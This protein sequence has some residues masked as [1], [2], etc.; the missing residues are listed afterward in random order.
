[1]SG[2]VNLKGRNGGSTELG[3]GCDVGEATPSSAKPVKGRAKVALIKENLPFILDQS[4]LRP[5]F[6]LNTRLCNIG[7]PE[8][9]RSSPSP[10]P[11]RQE[12]RRNDDR[13]TDNP[14]TGGGTDNPD[15]GGN[16]DPNTG[17]GTGG[18]CTN[19]VCD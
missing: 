6:R 4:S 13:G 5:R 8:F 11:I 7:A 12:E 2:K 14:D 17:G 1:M 9:G 3:S 15:T 18:S 16:G 19:G 10:E